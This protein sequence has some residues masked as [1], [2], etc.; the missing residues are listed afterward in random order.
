M[1]GEVI[2]YLQADLVRLYNSSNYIGIHDGAKILNGR[3]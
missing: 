1:I 2:R 3:I